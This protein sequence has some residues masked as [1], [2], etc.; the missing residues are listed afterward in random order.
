MSYSTWPAGPR[1][2]GV[3]HRRAPCCRRRRG[4]YLGQSSSA[5]CLISI[6]PE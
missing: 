5:A 1:P 4:K 6:G 2:Q 3:Q